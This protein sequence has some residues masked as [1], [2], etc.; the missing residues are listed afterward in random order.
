MIVTI[1]C[2]LGGIPFGLILSKIFAGMDPR[3]GGSGGIGFTNVMRTTNKKTAFMTLT[4]DTLK[5][6]LPVL[7]AKQMTPT[8][9]WI[10]TVALAAIL[11][12]IFSIYLRFKGG[13]G[14]ATSFGVLLGIS[15]AVAI[16]T[17]IIW[18]GVYFTWKYS[19]LGGLVSFGLL[20]LTFLVLG[21]KDYLFFAVLVVLIIYLKHVENI[22][23]LLAGTEKQMTSQSK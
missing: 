4:L 11:G 14:V 5:G 10:S 17:F 3:K 2:L 18:N 16:I 22:K 15:P 7:I 12:H 19:S 21:E 8:V 6:T 9:F 13:K 23:R 1:S 20:P